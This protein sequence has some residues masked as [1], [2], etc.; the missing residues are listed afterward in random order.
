M[1][2]PSL[3]HLL[4]MISILATQN[5]LNAL[6][7]MLIIENRNKMAAAAQWQSTQTQVIIHIVRVVIV[8]SLKGRRRLTERLVCVMSLSQYVW[9]WCPCVSL[10]WPSCLV[11]LV[12][13][14]LYGRRCSHVAQA[15]DAAGRTRNLATK[16][17]FCSITTKHTGKQ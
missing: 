8:T 4:S 17:N 6:Q 10:G 2:P 9:V 1:L 11:P 16:Q 5:S 7:V 12:D 14:F 3:C 13:L 15:A